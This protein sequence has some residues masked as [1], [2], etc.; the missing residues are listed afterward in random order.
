M[1]KRRISLLDEEEI[2][3]GFGDITL[4]RRL[5]QED[6][7]GYIKNMYSYPISDVILSS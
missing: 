1:E 3:Q 5:V 2:S 6:V 7:T 4:G